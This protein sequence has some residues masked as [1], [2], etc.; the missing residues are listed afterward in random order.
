MKPKVAKNGKVVETFIKT[1]IS[2]LN[3][4]VDDINVMTTE[5]DINQIYE[6]ITEFIYDNK[7]N[8]VDLLLQNLIETLT[9]KMEAYASLQGPNKTKILGKFLKHKSRMMNLYNVN[10]KYSES[11]ILLLVI[12][13]SR[14]G[15]DLYK[16]DL[17][18]GRIG[19]QIVELFLYP[20]LL[21]CFGLKA[22]DI[23]I[24]L[25]GCLLTQQKGTKD[26]KHVVMLI[27]QQ[28]EWP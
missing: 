10:L 11:S 8:Q 3:T 26:L 15:Y 28:S 25:N 24:S 20:P 17:E 19:E 22:D 6:S 4:M 27:C 18:N 21:G 5:S 16:R 14:R 12:F 2:V 13:Y 1:S 23:E 9:D 7:E